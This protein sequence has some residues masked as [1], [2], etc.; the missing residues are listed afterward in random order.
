MRSVVGIDVRRLEHH[1]VVLF[2]D[3]QT[4]SLSEA[5]AKQLRNRLN[6]MLSVV[7]KVRAVKQRELSE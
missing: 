6:A 5:E 2:P 1:L 7:A 4:V 3:G